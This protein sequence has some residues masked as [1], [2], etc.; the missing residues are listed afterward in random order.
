MP[1]ARLKT[2]S[3]G[4]S[5]HS[6]TI[7]TLVDDMF[8]TMYDAHGIGL[9]AIHTVF[10]SACWSST[11]NRDEAGEMINKPLIFVNPEILD[12]SEDQA[13]L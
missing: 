6:T 9:A 3:N 7:R 11:C 8:E 4:P 5:K 2:I 13:N 10:Q 1:D 12:P